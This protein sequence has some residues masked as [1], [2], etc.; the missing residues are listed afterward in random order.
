VYSGKVALLGGML[1]VG[2]T[3]A[4]AVHSARSSATVVATSACWVS[5]SEVVTVA[6]EIEG[7]ASALAYVADS[8]MVA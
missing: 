5:A 4:V 8:F 6:S 2:S 3:M 1:D 7:A